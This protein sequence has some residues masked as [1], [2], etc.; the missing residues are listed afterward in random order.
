MNHDDRPTLLL[1]C[2]G[3]SHTGKLTTMTGN[4]LRFRHPALVTRHVQL[5]SLARPLEKECDEDEYLIAVDGCEE[6]C[7]KKR[8]DL[9][10]KAPDAYLIATRK[11]IPKRGTEEPR[12]DEIECLSQA[13]L[14][15]IQALYSPP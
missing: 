6:C 7:V 12:Y 15:A 14:G 9:I 3:I 11:G 8:M 2:S 10:G 13:I 4:I 1:T 5:T